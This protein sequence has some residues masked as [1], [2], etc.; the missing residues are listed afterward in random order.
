MTFS[1]SS[2]GKT[3]DSMEGEKTISD[4]A[5]PVILD[6]ISVGCSM[7]SQKLWETWGWIKVDVHNPR[8]L[9]IRQYGGARCEAGGRGMGSS[10]SGPGGRGRVCGESH[11]GRGRVCVHRFLLCRR[12]LSIRTSYTARLPLHDMATSM[13]PYMILQIHAGVCHDEALSS[14]EPIRRLVR[15]Y[16][17]APGSRHND[18]AHNTN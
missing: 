8:K 7:S 15:T 3:Q 11:Q 5:I 18:D 10:S 12:P 9:A 2:M 4:G 17:Q 1:H 6:P 16:N 14:R 13:K